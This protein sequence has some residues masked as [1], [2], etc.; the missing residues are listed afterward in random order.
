MRRRAR[1]DHPGLWGYEAGQSGVGDI[2]G[3]FVEHFVPPRYHEEAAARGLDLHG[4]LSE[5]A[6]EQEV[7]EH[8][9]VAL[10]WQSGN[11]SV[12][13]DHE[14]SGLIVGLTLSTRAGGRLPGADR[15]DGVRH[16]HDHRGLRATTAC[17]CASSSSPAACSGT[18]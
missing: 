15:G 13:V 12:L 7:G 14:L 5:L 10:D 6:G 3:W 4:H 16:A 11:R 8:G 9:L 17:R 1:R 2:F 18:P